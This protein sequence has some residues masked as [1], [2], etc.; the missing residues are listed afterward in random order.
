MLALIISGCQSNMDNADNAE[1]AKNNDGNKHADYNWEYKKLGFDGE[2]I[3]KINMDS[4]GKIYVLSAG[5]IY[6]QNHEKWIQDD[7]EERAS[8]FCLTEKDNRTSLIAGTENG[9]VYLKTGDMNKWQKTDIECYTYPINEIA[10]VS[11]TETIYLGQSSKDGGGVWKSRDGGSTWN[12]LTDIT[13]RGIAIHPQKPDII[14]LVDRIAN[15]STDGGTSWRRIDTP[16]NYGV[17]IHPLYSDIAYIAYGNGFVT[18]DHE[19]VIIS[20]NRFFLSGGITRLQFNPAHINEWAL[21]IWDFP[22]GTGDLYYS[23]NSGNHWIKL[24]DKFTN[25][26]ITDLYFDREGSRLFVGTANN[27]LWVIKHE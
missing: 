5:R 3:T 17:L 22:S 12:K 13:A 20:N 6:Y 4:N 24:G 1:N 23:V 9:N 16:A 25:V 21:G 27:G 2:D 11:Q 14:Y 19:G 15:F 26:R 8:T 10:S 7:L 18:A